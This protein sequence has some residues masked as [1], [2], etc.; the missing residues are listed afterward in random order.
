MA[1]RMKISTPPNLPLSGEETIRSSS[2]ETTS[3]STRLSKGDSQVAGYDKGRLGGVRVIPKNFS[4][5]LMGIFVLLCAMPV[6]FAVLFSAHVIA[7]ELPD[8]TRPPVI[9][10]IPVIA[11]SGVADNQPT[12]LRSIIISK[13]RRAAIIDGETVELGGKH[14][15]TKLVEVN[16]GS[17]TLQSAQGRQV[18]TLFPDVKMTGKKEVKA[19]LQP[20]ANKVQASKQ[21]SGTVADKGKK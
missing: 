6:L 11:G 20:A 15:D 14:G 16:E 3:H 8:P 13:T 1:D 9:I 5:R 12:G 17:V 10:A 18:L 19:K 4:R 21:K 7:E 2:D